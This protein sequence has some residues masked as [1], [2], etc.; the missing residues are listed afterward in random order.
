MKPL[1]LSVVICTLNR[2]QPLVDTIRGILAMDYVPFELIIV[3]RSNQHEPETEAFLSQLASSGALQWLRRPGNNISAGRNIGVR[4]A[5]GDVIVF[6]DDDV[7]FRDT[8]Y[9]TACAAAYRDEDVVGVGGP[10]PYYDDSGIRPLPPEFW[11]GRGGWHCLHVERIEDCPELWGCN[12]SFRK[13]AIEHIGG[14]DQN[15]TSL[16]EE[17]DLCRRIRRL[18]RLVYEPD[19]FVYHIVAQSGGTRSTSWGFLVSRVASFTYLDMKYSMTPPDTF[20]L[21]E[22]LKT[23]LSPLLLALWIVR[24]YARVLVRTFAN[25]RRWEVSHFS[26]ELVH[27]LYPFHRFYPGFTLGWALGHYRWMRAG[28]PRCSTVEHSPVAPEVQSVVRA[29]ALEEE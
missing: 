2:D 9:L 26:G 28:C 18:G 25:E 16:G 24:E 23:I 20:R 6:V 5:R 7:R 29:E 8:G 10:S 27:K 4:Q 12:M 15:I 11:E 21:A 3:D 13:S 19:M 22:P 17:T 1:F 14:F